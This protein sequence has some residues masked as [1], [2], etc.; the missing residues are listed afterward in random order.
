[1]TSTKRRFCC[2]ISAG[3]LLI[4]LTS[5]NR[6][7]PGNKAQLL[8]TVRAAEHPIQFQGGPNGQLRKLLQ[9]RYEVLRVAVGLLNQQYSAGQVGILEIRD[10]IIE[11]LHAEADLSSTN[12]ER[13]KIY[14]KL[15]IILLQQDKPLAEAVNAGR[16]TQMEFLRARASTL[17]A[18]IQLEKLKFPQ[19]T[20][21]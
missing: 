18:Q 2:I 21:Q 16:V 19:E 11:M 13:I 9:E 20:F 6:W 15:V 14:E 1:M 4:C 5:P 3:L 12:T 10:A 7:L 8:T 17:Q